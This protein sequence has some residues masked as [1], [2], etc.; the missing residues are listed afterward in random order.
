MAI[1]DPHAIPEDATACTEY[2]TEADQ[3]W[4]GGDTDRAYELYHSLTQSLAA[5]DAQTSHAQYRLALIAV[6]RGDHDLA[7]DLLSRSSEPGAADLRRSLDNATPN[8]PVAD[9]DVV[10]LTAEQTDDWWEAGVAAKHAGDWDLAR[11]FFT[12]I[13]S[14]TCNGPDVIA[15]AE[16]LV[17]EATHQLGEDANARLWFE[18]AL[19]NLSGGTAEMEIA[20][21]MLGEVGVHATAD[22]SSPAAEQLVNGIEAYQQG[23]LA[24]ARTALEA[25]LHLDG[26]A[27]VKGRARY[28]L[29]ALDYQDRRYADARNH[30]EEAARSAPDQERA[31]AT[32]MLS[33][34]WDEAA[35]P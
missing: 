8:D 12:S 27:E 24:A 33:W 2:R 17:G 34:H 6:N 16:V 13:A 26:P 15:R 23:D 31:W 10:P 9:P 14:S 29:G 1:P 18:K 28:Y 4:D 35:A 11:R 19:P 30:L 32:E 3:A 25:T 20:R 22:H 7:Y 5:T 21:T